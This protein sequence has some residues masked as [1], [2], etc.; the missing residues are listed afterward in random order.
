MIS[1][2]LPSSSEPE[3]VTPLEG[4]WDINGQA[5]SGASGSFHGTWTV[6]S[7]SAAGFTGSYD[8]LE[9]AAPTGQRRL[10]GPV[11]GRMANASTT[12]FDVS[13]AGSTRRHVGTL[14]ADTVRGSW[15]DVSANGAVEAS[16]SFRAVRR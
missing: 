16:G 10:T 12:E 1:G 8:V 3:G 4:L 9:S 5:A 11:A 2:C 13:V 14:V 7:T 15:F 6:R